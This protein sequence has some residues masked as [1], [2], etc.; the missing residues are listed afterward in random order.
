MTPYYPE[1][2]STEIKNKI[3]QHH[4]VKKACECE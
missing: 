4:K 2:S 3:K 1:Q